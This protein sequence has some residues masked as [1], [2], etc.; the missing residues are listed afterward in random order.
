VDHRSSRDVDV[1][2]AAD[3]DA[4]PLGFDKA[5]FVSSGATAMMAGL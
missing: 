1:E 5:D 4:E 2:R 3:E